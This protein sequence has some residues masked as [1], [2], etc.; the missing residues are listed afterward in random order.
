MSPEPDQ[1]FAAMRDDLDDVVLAEPAALRQVG[2]RRNRTNRLVGLVAVIALVGGAAVGTAWAANR[3]TG[4]GPPVGDATPS[5]SPS[6]S[7]KLTPTPTGETATDEPADFCTNDGPVPYRLFVQRAQG[8][9]PD[10]DCAA[11]ESREHLPAPCA[12]AP[13]DTDGKIIARRTITMYVQRVPPPK[14][15]T[16]P[17]SFAAET[18]TAYRADGAKGY[19]TDLR[20]D[21][22]RCPTVRRDGT[23]YR[24]SIAETGFAGDESLLMKVS[25]SGDWADMKYT[26]TELVAVVRVG[27][28]VVVFF[29]HGW[30][31]NSATP[32]L[33]KRLARVAADRIRGWQP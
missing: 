22:A 2:S 20:N 6:P 23:T 4:L 21:L 16:T 14:Q 28:A 31:I 29:A 25:H 7:P 30:E 3:S 32:D 12:A 11:A 33:T 8:G 26:K 19:L 13:H 15:S 5:P 17:A 9:S 10:D 18:L 24:H 1:L 27:R